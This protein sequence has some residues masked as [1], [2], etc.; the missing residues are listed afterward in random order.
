[1]S[2]S[3]ASGPAKRLSGTVFVSVAFGMIALYAA[4]T[5]APLVA[6][7]I[8][9]TRTWSGIPG[10]AA[11][12]G[13]AGGA[14]TLSTLMSRRGRRPGLVAGWVVG[15]LGALIALAAVQAGS[16]PLL[17]V[18]MLVVGVGHGANQLARFAAADPYPVARRGTVLSFVV[19]AGTIGAVVGPNLLEPTGAMADRS[20]MVPLAGGYLTAAAAFA[21]AAAITTVALRPDPASLGGASQTGSSD[22]RAGWGRTTLVAVAALVAAQFVMLLIMTM[23]PVHIRGHEHGLAAVGVVM[24]IH[25]GAMFALAP[26][27]G[28]ASDRFG[29]LRVGLV[30]LLLV[31]VSG[32]MAATA[33][34]TSM[35]LLAGAL[36]LLGLGWSAAFVASSA[37]LARAG[38]T[39]QGRA[40][41]V[42][43]AFAALAS[44]TSGMLIAS[45]GYATMC[46]VGVAISGL[47]AAVVFREIRRPTPETPRT[48]PLRMRPAD[49]ASR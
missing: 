39:V 19:W 2:N 41:A 25:F 36:L 47:A 5:A 48:S 3:A 17:V 22:H 11:I 23:T 4:F 37:L 21:I 45:I 31:A 24:S 27:A 15:V 44:V 10:A 9:G 46:L 8:T 18:A 6:E 49:V 42:G 35:T 40:D 1:M 13:T 43:W 16:F 32:I 14:A 20:G 26:L 33:P 29:A 30:G 38:V 12:L 28:K 34:T 7:D